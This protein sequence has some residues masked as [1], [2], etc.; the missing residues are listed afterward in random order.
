MQALRRRIRQIDG[1]AISVLL[2]RD[3]AATSGTN[4]R[5]SPAA[6]PLRKNAAYAF[7]FQRFGIP[8]DVVAMKAERSHR[9]LMK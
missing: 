4:A 1:A 7:D 3:L 9:S 2:P 6:L 5:R 8:C